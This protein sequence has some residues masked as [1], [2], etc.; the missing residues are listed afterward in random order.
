MYVEVDFKATD[1]K[2]AKLGTPSGDRV[3]TKAIGLGIIA[4]VRMR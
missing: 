2:G 1:L 3:D 4:D